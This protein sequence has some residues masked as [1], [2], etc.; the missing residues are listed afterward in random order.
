M[1]AARLAPAPPTP[2]P[3]RVAGGD[4]SGEADA[5]RAPLPWEAWAPVE[6]ARP[7]PPV[8]GRAPQADVGAPTE[9]RPPVVTPVPT[10]SA[11][12]AAAAAAPLPAVEAG[13]SGP[14]SLALLA[15]P[16]PPSLTPLLNWRRRAS[17]TPRAVAGPLG[18]E[19]VAMPCE[20]L[21]RVPVLE[22]RPPLESPGGGLFPGV[23]VRIPV[24]VPPCARPPYT[25]ARE[26][27]ALSICGGGVGT[28]PLGVANPFVCWAGDRFLGEACVAAVGA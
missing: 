11:A 21:G 2:C 16:G 6:E 5:A 12:S 22:V 17:L 23:D 3:S 19:G 25:P 28:G 8:P 13:R 27:D 18:R 14:R 7:P 1:G 9:A 24:G 20:V 4:M 10:S 15:L 26:G